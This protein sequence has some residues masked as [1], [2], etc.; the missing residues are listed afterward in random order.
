MIFFVYLNCLPVLPKPLT[1]LFLL[2]EVTY[3]IIHDKTN[4]KRTGYH[5]YFQRTHSVPKGNNPK[6]CSVSIQKCLM[7]PCLS[8][9]SACGF[10]Y[11]DNLRIKARCLSPPPVTVSNGKTTVS[12]PSVKREEVASGIAILKSFWK[13]DEGSF[14]WD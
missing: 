2:I 6:S 9:Y 3:I 10:L 8:H 7:I 1:K 13:Y 14:P 4:T 5:S 12:F 11:F